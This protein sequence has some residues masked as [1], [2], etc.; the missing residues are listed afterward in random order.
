MENNDPLVN[1]LIWE[2]LY[3]QGKNDLLYPNDIFVRMASRNFDSG[4]KDVLDYGMGTGANLMH[5]ARRG[6]TVAGLEV[7]S[8]AVQIVS[9]RL[10]GEMLQADLKISSIGESLPWEKNYFDAVVAWQVL[11]YNDRSS[12]KFSISEIDRVLRPGGIF[13]AATAAPGDIS[14]V[15]SIPL[16][17]SIYRSSV[18]DQ[19]NCLMLIPERD[20]LAE[21]FPG[22]GIEIGEMGYTFG[23]YT[24]KHWLITYRKPN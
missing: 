23:S 11:Y 13:I 1:Q 16:G 3:S 21:C 8:S 22:W 6:Y 9:K 24:A 14:H 20:E 10:K 19:E 17:N 18:P 5:L 2:R 4:I 15:Q 12:W 7:S